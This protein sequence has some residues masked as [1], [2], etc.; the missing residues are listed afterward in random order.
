M[1]SLSSLVNGI[2]HLYCLGAN[3]DDPTE[4]ADALHLPKL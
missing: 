3:C 2:S 1:K 4:D